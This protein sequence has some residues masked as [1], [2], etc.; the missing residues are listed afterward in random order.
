MSERDTRAQ[1]G[2]A[3]RRGRALIVMLVAITSASA[4]LWAL[5]AR[6]A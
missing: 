6:L 1:A 3:R 4:A 5:A 2:P